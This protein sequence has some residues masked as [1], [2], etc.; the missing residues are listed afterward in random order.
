M[1]ERGEQLDPIERPNKE[2]KSYF[3]SYSFSLKSGVQKQ[4][5]FFEYW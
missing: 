3:Y 2:P 5:I 1:S 4:G